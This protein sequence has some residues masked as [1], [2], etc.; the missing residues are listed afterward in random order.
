MIEH[1]NSYLI[2]IICWLISL[3]WSLPPLFDINPGFMREAQGFDCG[4]NW[5]RTDIESNRLKRLRIDRKFA[6]ATMITVLYYV[7]AWTP[8]TIFAIIQTIGTMYSFDYQLPFMLITASA[9]TA[10]IAVIGQ[11]CVYFY[12]VRPSDKRSSITSP[13]LK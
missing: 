2:P 10:K 6:Q 13:T 3:S 9:L 1:K 11:S 8:Y 7:L 5:K 12:T 4:L